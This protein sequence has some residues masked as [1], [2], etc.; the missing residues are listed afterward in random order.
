M[1][2]SDFDLATTPQL[3]CDRIIYPAFAAPLLFR[4]AVNKG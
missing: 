1:K 2:I 4:V 3:A